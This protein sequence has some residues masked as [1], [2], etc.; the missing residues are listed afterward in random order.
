MNAAFR[1]CE[2]SEAIHS[3]AGLDFF[4][5]RLKAGVLAMTGAGR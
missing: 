5:P 3:G 1:H 4:V 2:R